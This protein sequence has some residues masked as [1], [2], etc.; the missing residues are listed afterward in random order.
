M[1]LLRK[2][3][4]QPPSSVG[5]GKTL[6][7]AGL[8]VALLARAARG[9]GAEGAKEGRGNAADG[10]RGVQGETAV[11]WGDFHLEYV[12]PLQT[13]YPEDSD[14][15]LVMLAAAHCAGSGSRGSEISATATTT[16][17][18]TTNSNSNSSTS[19]DDSAGST[20][21]SHSSSLHFTLHSPNY[22]DAP[23]THTI[24]SHS[25]SPSAV[26]QSP[27]RNHPSL[28]S[29]TP[30]VSLTCSTLWAWKDPVSPHL[31]ARESRAAV[32]K[33]PERGEGGG[34]GAEAGEE[35]GEGMGEEAADAA[36]VDALRSYVS[37]SRSSSSDSS[38]GDS[39][40]V[41]SGS[42]GSS[43]GSNGRWVLIET[44]GGMA[45]PG[46][47]GTLQAD[48]YRP[49]RLPCILVGDGR[50][51]GI[52]VTVA[53]VDS[54]AGRGYD[55][56]AVVV[57]GDEE[58]RLDNADYLKTYLRPRGI[59]VISLPALPSLPPSVSDPNSPSS[60]SFSSPSLASSP[61][62]SPSTAFQTSSY[63]TLNPNLI[64][65]LGIS[66]GSF[67]ELVLML[68][69]YHGERLRALERAA[70]RAHEILW[71]PFT[72]H[73]M[74]GVKDVSV[75]DSRAGENFSVFRP[76]QTKVRT[77]PQSD[78][79]TEGRA[80]P[81]GEVR[82]EDRLE[83]WFDGCASWWTQGLGPVL[84]GELSREIGAAMAR[85]GHVM[86]PENAHA[87]ALEASELLL[88]GVGKGWAS[89]VFFSD[90]G[91]TAIEV[92]L[93]MAFRSFCARNGVGSDGLA[94]LKVIALTGSYHGDTLAAMHAQ[95]PSPY[96]SFQQQPWYGGKGVF[97]DPPTVEYSQGQWL[98][99]LPPSLSSSSTTPPTTHLSFQSR[100]AVFHSERDS[101]PLASIYHQYMH[102]HLQPFLLPSDSSSGGPSGAM[103]AA[104]I[105]EPVLHGAGGMV[106]IDPLFQRTLV[107][108]C[109]T[110]AIPVI[111]DEVFAGCWR[112]GTQSAAELLACSPDIACYAKLLTGGMIPLAVTLA[113]SS[114]F[115][116]FYGSSKLDALLHGHSYTAHPAGCAAACVSLKALSDP[117]RNP[118]LLPDGSQLKELWDPSLVEQISCHPLIQR[119]LAIGTVF[120]AELKTD[121]AGYGSSAAK[122]LLS[123]LRQHGIYARPLGNVVYFMCGPFT[124]ASTCSR[125]LRILLALLD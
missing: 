34:E 17:D 115:D 78:K 86:F 43:S 91:S 12:K 62:S 75:I 65:W 7:S 64:D 24:S 104:L 113:S 29:P 42:G 99:V 23:S 71:W 84:Q 96:T 89:R 108:F 87:L 28:Q 48:L 46:P 97:L 27:A 98:V 30:T 5:V 54:L 2:D 3:S 92:A 94:D 101:S 50:L 119:V 1:S 59:P 55:V 70:E 124:P 33:S 105:I 77:D 25:P 40:S 11:N 4:S 51:G 13:G 103:A 6:V 69:Q 9:G 36:V 76:N 38:S 47:S 107:S 66:E 10:E 111:L 93:K 19:S 49:L 81:R 39:S 112:L 120:V 122:G 67:Q 102:H 15:R 31:A 37:C 116:A 20:I 114:V 22:S 85:Y 8:A 58:G 53:A 110:H 56:A 109:R 72:Q 16:G 79:P 18:N 90:N 80:E 88:K 123:R 60:S 121:A 125:L 117:A 45:S 74:V 14:A 21:A 68:E 95:S 41:S 63:S 73:G 106:M 44:A 35:G 100:T 61:S 52:S 32:L 57:C 82:E 118:N 83:E 26:A